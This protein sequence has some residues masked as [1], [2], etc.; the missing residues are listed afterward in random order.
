MASTS[1]YFTF[2]RNVSEH[3]P[4]C[5]TFL[6]VVCLAYSLNLKMEAV[7][8]FETFLTSYQIPQDRNL[9]KFVVSK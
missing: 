8:S 1:L 9:E 3:L 4:D 7:R 5:T 2:L 6:S